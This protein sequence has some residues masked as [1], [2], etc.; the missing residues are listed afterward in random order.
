MKSDR[1]EYYSLSTIEGSLK[2]SIFARLIYA[3]CKDPKTA[4][5]QDWL[6]AAALAVRDRLV[7]RWME[8]ER[9]QRAQDAKRV[10]YLSMDVSVVHAF[11][12]ALSALGILAEV[13]QILR[14]LG[15]E[16]E[17]ILLLEDGLALGHG[18]RGQ[19]AA[20]SLDSMATLGVAGFGY[21]IRRTSGVLRRQIANGGE[22]V[23]PDYH[24]WEI[25]QPDSQYVVRFGGRVERQGETSGWVDTED[26]VAVGYDSI[27]PG[28]GTKVA[29]TLR[30]WSA[31]P[32]SE[33]KF[34]AFHCGH[35][36]EGVEGKN[37]SV[38]L[39]HVLNRDDFTSDDRVLL[40]RQ[41]YFFV[42]ASLQDLVRRFLSKHD[43]FARLPEFVAIHVNDYH[44]VLAIPELMRLL[45]DEHGMAWAQAWALACRV[46][47][48][49]NRRV[50]CEAL[51]T[52]PVE[53]LSRLLPRH[54]ELIREINSELLDQVI[55]R[56]GKD[57]ALLR[58]VSLID[59]ADEPGVRVA[60]LAIVGSHKVTGV[61]MPPPEM[62]KQSTFSDLARV[63]PDRFVN[64]AN[65][66]S[67]RRWLSQIN[68][69]LSGVIDRAI[70]DDW[71]R[72]V[73]RLDALRQHANKPDFVTAIAAAKRDNKT[74]L[75]TWI[76]DQLGVRVQ[77]NSLFDVQVAPIRECKR[78]LLNLLHVVTRYNRIVANPTTDW[79][80][81]TVIFAGQ[82]D[83]ADC[84][85]TQIATLIRDV[86]SKVN[87]DERVGERLRVAFIPRYNVNV[88]EMIVSA[89]DLCEQ[90]SAPGTEVSRAVHMKLALNGALTIGAVD[91]PHA[92]A[93][94]DV[95]GDRAFN[96]GYR[97]QQNASFRSHGYESREMDER[98]LE[99]AHA[100]DQIRD[101]FFCP[102]GLARFHLVFDEMVEGD[103]RHRVLAD[104]PG[105]VLMQDEVD[106]IYRRRYEWAKRAI[107]NIVDMC[108]SS[109]DRVVERHLSKLWWI[110][111]MDFMVL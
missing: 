36:R 60:H 19:L 20:C 57:P 104:Y 90:I 62:T 35:N 94:E 17:A 42:S 61:S 44:A 81:R 103:D 65:G 2:R 47:S 70:G 107:F 106:V 66:V 87:M 21:G 53:T 50:A 28:H 18:D 80:R 85:A 105:Y 109:L 7:D 14:E 22:R 43:D 10:Y 68:P 31:K 15:V 63:F 69:P 84:M 97:V 24:L 77:S 3:L 33:L 27:I 37:A 6:Q 41:E 110:N 74:R 48:F 73:E 92:G 45:I 78:Q 76:Q 9:A 108:E 34:S 11:V 1:L 86:A 25:P 4:A 39:S 79:V 23:S 5:P 64:I 16:L 72:N 95:G 93:R 98:N 54:L 26:V 55:G 49:T 75:A 111:S 46:F 13:K 38:D 96:F 52:W 58:G 100:L 88:E 29:N 71:R 30:L 40:L 51:D 12:N 67:H 56:L 59:E 99:L 32:G 102:N 82:A 91:G 89:A 8:T 101:G 83:A